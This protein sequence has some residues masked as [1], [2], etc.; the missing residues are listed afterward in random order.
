MCVA[1]T[2]G[3]ERVVHGKDFVIW[4]GVHVNNDIAFS[5]EIACKGLNFSFALLTGSECSGG[6]DLYIR[7]G[8]E[9][10]NRRN[11]AERLANY[12]A[13]MVLESAAQ[14]CVRSTGRKVKMD[15]H[16]DTLAHLP[17]SSHPCLV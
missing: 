5:L 4:S 10:L 17:H 6:I 15:T 16:L 11:C 12:L 3:Q 7:C 1:V 14:R 2:S 9:T 8:L 13:W